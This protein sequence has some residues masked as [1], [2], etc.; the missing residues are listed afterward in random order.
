MDVDKDEAPSQPPSSDHNAMEDE[1]NSLIH[2]DQE[3]ADFD[4][5]CLQGDTVEITLDSDDEPPMDDK[6]D[7]MDC[8]DE[9]GPATGAADEAEVVDESEC[10]L[11]HTDSVLTC[12]FRTRGSTVQVC[13]GGMDEVGAIWSISG[14]AHILEKHILKGHTDSIVSVAYSHNSELLA[15]ASYDATVKVWNA[16][17]GALISTC[18]G[19]TQE[20]EWC[21][22]HPKGNVL[23]AG[24][25]DMTVWM[26]WAPTGKVMQVFGGHGGIV[27][28]GAFTASGKIV[29]TGADDGGVIIWNPKEGTPSHNL[30]TM[31]RAA[32]VSICPYPDESKNVVI[33]GAA[34][35][36]CKVLHVETG[37]QLQTLGGHEQSVEAIGFSRPDALLP[38]LATADLNGRLAIWDAVTYESRTTVKKAHSDGIVDLEWATSD[39]EASHLLV[40]CS[41]DATSKLWDGRSGT[42][43]RTFT[44][45]QHLPVLAVDVCVIGSDLLVASASDDETCK[46]YRHALHT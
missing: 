20:V 3:A 43:L 31:H 16:D 2:V 14:D 37:K 23:L 34:D 22:W 19:P 15:T 33:T 32:V 46:I 42:L 18:E 1:A 4:N 27:S 35:G 8:I 6:D 12:A 7:D 17:T 40:T 38:L 24:S 29:V 41:S 30:T 28:S 26:W 9:D 44:G 5:E 13:T 21:R 25:T 45:H 10:T 36:S 39:V 11:R